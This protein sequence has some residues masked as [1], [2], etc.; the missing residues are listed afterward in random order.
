[1]G[2]SPLLVC[3]KSISQFIKTSFYFIFVHHFDPIVDCYETTTF[4]TITCSWDV[5]GVQDIEPTVE[6][7]ETTTFNK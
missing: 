4:N 1:M 2:N 6:S 5:N 3:L 7:Y